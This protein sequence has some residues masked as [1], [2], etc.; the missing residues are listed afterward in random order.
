MSSPFPKLPVVL[1]CAL[2]ILLCGC[3]RK[4]QVVP[5]PPPKVI[6]SHPVEKRVTDYV[7]F[8]GTTDA[9]QFVQVRARVEGWLE[10][11]KF[12]PGARVK[13]GELLFVI[14][15]RP[16]QAE[17]D[18]KKALLD[19]RQADLNLAQTNLRR[20]KDLLAS[21]SISQLQFDETKAKELVAQSQVEIAKAELEEAKLDLAYTSVE[22]AIN[23]RVSRNYV[24][25]GN[26][27]G[28]G[29]KT[30]LT[31]IV[32]DSE[33]YV[34]FEVSEREYL[35]F[36]RMHEGRLREGEAKDS[37]GFPVQ[38]QLADE[39][40]FPHEGR[41][42]FVEPKLDESTGTVQVRAVFP[43][44]DGFLQAGLFG[45]VRIPVRTRTA[46]LVPESAVGISQAGRYVLTVNK[47]NKVE[48]KTVETGFLDGTRR[49][50]DKGLSKTD[51]VVVNGIQRARPG[52][53]VDP[54]EQEHS[55]SDNKKTSDSPQPSSE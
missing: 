30:L 20:A 55:G 15:P 21:A 14:D 45:R 19:A 5:P 29:E 2:M 4:K 34:Y 16:F 27:V 40:D 51:R 8:T 23:G 52:R 25:V 44:K 17:V 35:K 50:I 36:K 18:R 32:N 1:T 54:Q 39:K 7:T 22:S 48:S 10:T 13:K 43:N 33:I 6:V 53:K 3:E 28:A 24:D 11:I 49:V 42:D 26:L 37:K 38:L 47:D 41:I 46:L 31:E 9:L 12:E